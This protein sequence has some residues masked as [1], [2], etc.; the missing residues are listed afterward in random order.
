M[1]EP[2][3]DVLWLRE[4]SIL[5]DQKFSFQRVE[6]R[7]LKEKYGAERIG[8]DQTGMGENFFEDLVEEHGAYRLVGYLFNPAVKHSLATSLLEH[9]EDR[10]IR[11]SDDDDLELDLHSIKRAKTTGAIPERHF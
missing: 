9:M 10:K 4:L 7:R 11:I 1:L 6:V 2:V 3:G 5:K 8:V